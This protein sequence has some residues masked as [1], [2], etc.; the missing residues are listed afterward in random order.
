[1]TCNKRILLCDD[2][3]ALRMM[4]A[5]VLAE[6]G[7]DVVAEADNGEA[8]VTQYKAHQPDVV[9]LDLVMPRLDGKQALGQILAHDAKAKVVIL[10]S[11]GAKGDIEECLRMGASSYLQKP[12][13]TETMLRVL[14]EAVA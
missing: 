9:L 12:I 3:R 7:F 2:S 5:N 4:S 14:R 8:A 11:L 6:H 1:M 10:S 13:D